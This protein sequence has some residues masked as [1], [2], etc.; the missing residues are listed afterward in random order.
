MRYT[1]NAKKNKEEIKMAK[2]T[3]EDVEYL[4]SKA[5]LGYEEAV[6]RLEGHDGDMTA[7]LVELEKEGLLRGAEQSKSYTNAGRDE[8]ARR[9][10][11]RCSDFGARF[12]KGL[13]KL[14]RTAMVVRHQE[15]EI[16][17]VPVVI[18]IALL[19]CA[20]KLT[21]ILA[22]LALICGCR[23]RFTRTR[24]PVADELRD[25]IKKAADTVK[26]KVNSMFEDEEGE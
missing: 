20:T 10:R 25:G 2:F 23:V 14:L 15:D 3:L 11:E 7:I 1:V 19:L 17:R 26:E 13:K 16:I 4:R 21:L 8:D 5:N 18:P 6:A 9:A 12:H 22:V 24:R